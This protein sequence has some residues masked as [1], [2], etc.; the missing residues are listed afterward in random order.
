MGTR[1]GKSN[2]LPVFLCVALLSD[3]LRLAADTRAAELARLEESCR[4]AMRTAMANAN[5]A[6]VCPEPASVLSTSQ[7][8]NKV[9]GDLSPGESFS[10]YPISNQCKHSPLPKPST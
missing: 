5:K 1:I 4:A 8:L 2:T 6:Q 7:F 3:Q 9:L 10:L